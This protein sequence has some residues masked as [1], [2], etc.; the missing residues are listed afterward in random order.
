MKQ[1]KIK[2]GR[3][4][5]CISIT[6]LLFNSAKLQCQQRAD[7]IDSVLSRYSMLLAN[8][9]LPLSALSG[10]VKI[11]KNNSILFKHPYYRKVQLISTNPLELLVVMKKNRWESGRFYD[12]IMFQPDFI[13]IKRNFISKFYSRPSYF[14]YF[15]LCFNDSVVSKGF[16]T[17]NNFP[18][19]SVDSSSTNKPGINLI[20]FNA[21]LRRQKEVLFK[22]YILSDG[23]ADGFITYNLHK[24]DY[25]LLFIIFQMTKW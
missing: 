4:I 9:N 17:L 21:I 2:L 15:F 11:K 18:I 13:K 19:Q 8:V 1:E 14:N 5:T 22:Y 7:T 24:T 10:K 16:S 3:F 20:K 25:S 23:S 12:S 6:Y